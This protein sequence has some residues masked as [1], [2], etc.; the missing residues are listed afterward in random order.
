MIDVNRALDDL[1]RVDARKVRLAELRFFLGCTV[2]ESAELLGVSI[3]TAERDLVLLRSWL[4]GRLNK[5]D[6]TVP[7]AQSS[8]EEA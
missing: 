3:T 2:T 1:E 6:M 5:R 7:A 8:S 4:Y